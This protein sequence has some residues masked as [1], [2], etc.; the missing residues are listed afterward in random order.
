MKSQNGTNVSHS[1]WILFS[2]ILS[3]FWVR[4]GISLAAED[5][6][7]YKADMPTARY[8]VSACVVDG[9]IYTF[10]GADQNLRTYAYTSVEVYNPATNT[11]T[12]KTDM[13]T[14][15]FGLGTCAMNGKIYA[16]GGVT[17]GLV[18]VT[19]NK[20][21]DP[22]TDTWATKSPL[23]VRRH[24]YFL[25]SVGDKI[26]AIA[27][28]YPDP[29][30]P[31]EPVIPTSTEE[32]DTG[33]G[34]PSPDFNSDGVVDIEDLVILI[35]SWGTDDPLCDIAPFPDG[36]GI[37]DILRPGSIYGLLGAGEYTGRYRRR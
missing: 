24:T 21:Y 1:F 34:V 4:A 11:W 10:G 6:W 36:D 9:K 12:T 31:S 25:G 29:Q 26:Y 3:G 32:Y 8:S 5:T 28:S 33:L 19:T 22:V 16:V 35:E 15:R 14:S 18:V 7:T 2:L 20:R 13:P 17:N 30:N 37:V 23:Q 27:G